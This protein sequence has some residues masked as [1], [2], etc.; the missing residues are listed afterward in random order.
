[1]LGVGI[2]RIDIGGDDD[3][4]VHPDVAEP[5]RLGFA[6]D[7]HRAVAIRHRAAHECM[8]SDVQ[9]HRLEFPCARA[10]RASR[11]TVQVGILTSD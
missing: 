7:F 5:E 6:S 9:G 3:M 11:V 4:I 1:V 2:T 10:D 8:N